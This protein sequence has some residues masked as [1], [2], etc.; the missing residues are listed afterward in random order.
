[1]TDRRMLSWSFVQSLRPLP[2]GKAEYSIYDLSVPAL[3]V[4]IHT[5]GSTSYMLCATLL[6]KRINR[7]LWTRISAA[8]FRLKKKGT[9]LFAFSR[10][11]ERK[12]RPRKTR[13]NRP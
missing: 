11:Q 10:T 6:G 7:C 13:L 4:R 5:S 3:S 9:P 2:P 1:M 8:V 12:V